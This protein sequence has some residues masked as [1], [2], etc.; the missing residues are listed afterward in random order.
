MSGDPLCPGLAPTALYISFR[1]SLFIRP[2]S[3]GGGH[4]SDFL[5]THAFDVYVDV[6]VAVAVLSEL[7]H[8]AAFAIYIYLLAALR[9]THRVPD[10][11]MSAD[12]SPHLTDGEDGKLKSDQ[13]PAAK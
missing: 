11:A 4:R 2:L 10:Y 8:F 9:R 13:M 6:A 12:G 3:V 7:T 5:H 1:C